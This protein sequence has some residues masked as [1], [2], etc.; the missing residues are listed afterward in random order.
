[1]SQTNRKTDLFQ[2]TLRLLVLQLLLH[3]SQVPPPLDRV[4]LLQAGLLR[5]VSVQTPSFLLSVE[6]LSLAL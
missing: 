3:L 5:P 1:M 2:G 4:L 6:L